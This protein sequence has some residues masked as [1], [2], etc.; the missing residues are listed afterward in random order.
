MSILAF[1]FDI[2]RALED[3]DAPYMLIGAFP[4]RCGVKSL[5]LLRMTLAESGNP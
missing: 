3:I 1:Y 4:E 5:R 2:V